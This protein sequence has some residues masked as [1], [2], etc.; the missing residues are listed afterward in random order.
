MKFAGKI[1]AAA[2]MSL[3]MARPA[4]AQSPWWE[5]FSNAPQ[6]NQFQQWLATHPNAANALGANPYQIYDPTWRARNPELQEYIQRNPDSVVR[7]RAHK[8]DAQ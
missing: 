2:I 1:V 7:G 6:G 5:G 8:Q 3:A 4:M